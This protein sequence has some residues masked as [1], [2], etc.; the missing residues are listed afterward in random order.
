MHGSFRDK[1]GTAA[2][3]SRGGRASQRVAP[4]RALWKKARGHVGGQVILEPVLGAESAFFLETGG[5]T[6]WEAS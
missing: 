1:G 3:H 5:A 4:A 2:F 6:S